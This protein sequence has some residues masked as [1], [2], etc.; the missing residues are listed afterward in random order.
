M[1]TLKLGNIELMPIERG[2]SSYKEFLDWC[3]GLSD[4]WKKSNYKPVKYIRGLKKLG[5]FGNI[6]KNYSVSLVSEIALQVD[7]DFGFS[8]DGLSVLIDDPIEIEKFL[9]H[10]DAWGLDKDGS[11]IDLKRGS[12]N[13]IDWSEEKSIL[14]V[15]REI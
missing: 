3:D 8:R 6:K 7:D 12:T 10:E 2:F 15:I 1:R 14:F 9:N 5:I 4:G 11:E 13:I